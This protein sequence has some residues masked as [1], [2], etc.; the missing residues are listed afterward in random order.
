MNFEQAVDIQKL[1]NSVY[2]ISILGPQCITQKLILGSYIAFTG[3]QSYT[4]KFVNKG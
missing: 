1:R 4:S 3:N 2:L